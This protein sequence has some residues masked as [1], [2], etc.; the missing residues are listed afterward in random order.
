[1]NARPQLLLVHMQPL[2]N[3]QQDAKLLLVK[4][5]EGFIGASEE[6][7]GAIARG[8]ASG[9]TRADDLLVHEFAQSD[10]FSEVLADIEAFAEPP[11]DSTRGRAYSLEESFERVNRAYFG[12]AMP[13]PRLE[14]SRMLTG[15]KFG[16]Y[17][18]NRDTVM[19][20]VS[21]DDAHVPA[22][23]VDFVM[24]HEL[25][26]KKHGPVLVNGRRLVHTPVFRAEERIFASYDEAQ[27]HLDALAEGGGL[28][29]A[30]SAGE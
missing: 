20:S 30:G 8:A 17:R 5:S 24:Y 18:Q 15:T 3:K 16:H 12:G 19:L 14:W 2:W 22:L 11:T 28:L 23:V 10:D 13:R 26:H 27:R 29:R 25:L 4:A 9:R 1:M 7:W 6:V 21:L